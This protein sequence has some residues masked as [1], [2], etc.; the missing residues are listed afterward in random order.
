MYSSGYLLSSFINEIKYETQ[1][2][3]VEKGPIQNEGQ[4]LGEW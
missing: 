3:M 2:Q 4:W 1:D